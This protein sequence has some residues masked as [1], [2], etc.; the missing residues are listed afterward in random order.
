MFSCCESASLA[1]HFPPPT[2]EKMIEE[3]IIII[4]STGA[5][6]DSLESP[7]S[8]N[9]SQRVLPPPEIPVRAVEPV[10]KGDTVCS[11]PPTV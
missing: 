5:E 7:D 10:A 1:S 3:K 6:K 4:K 11:E 8:Q 9:K 2:R